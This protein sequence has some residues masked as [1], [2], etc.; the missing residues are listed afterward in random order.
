MSVSITLVRALVEEVVRAGADPDAYLA[1]A[2]FDRALLDE[3]SAR[4]DVAV[5]DRL[6]ELALDL[7]G[8]PALGLHMAERARLAAFH[9]VGHLSSHCKTARQALRA[10]TRY[11]RL[12]SDAEPPTLTEQGDTA[13]VTWHFVRGGERGDRLR[14]ELGVTAIVKIAQAALGMTQPPRTVEFVHA[15]PPYAAEYHR[16]LGCPVRFG[17][18]AT[19]IHFDRT[20]LDVPQI[21]ANGALF[22]L[23]EGQALRDLARLAA[24]PAVS[25]RVRAAI[26]GSY[27]G[28]RPTMDVVARRLSVSERSLRRRLQSEGRTYAELVDEAMAELARQMLHDPANTLQAIADRLGFSEPSAFHR[29]FKRWTGLTPSRYRADAGTLAPGEVADDGA[30]AAEPEALSGMPDDDAADPPAAPPPKKP[31]FLGRRRFW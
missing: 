3:P 18:D 30:D 4:V 28:T 7:T 15:A 29:A 24:P 10:L 8:D 23:L 19:R 11:R 14:A 21:H 16:V 22:Q 13:T 31:G 1:A 25:A 12:L 17:S 5:Y 26:L 27:D 2:G 6:D 20:L 9:V